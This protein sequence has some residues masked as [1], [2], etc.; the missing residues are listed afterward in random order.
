MT[1]N[2]RRMR[3]TDTNSIS[4]GEWA[5]PVDLDNLVQTVDAGGR[6]DWCDGTVMTV[7]DPNRPRLL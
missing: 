1:F 2:P 7:A 6:F 3:T 5:S 4:A